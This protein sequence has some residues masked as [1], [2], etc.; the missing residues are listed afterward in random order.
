MTMKKP[1]PYT[2]KRIL[3]WFVGFFLIV[4]L[5]NG[6]M[7]YFALTTWPGLETEKPYIKGLNYNQEITNAK[8]QRI[9]NWQIMITE[10]PTKTKDGYFEI[11]ITKPDES[12]APTQVNATFFRAVQEGFDQKITLAPLGN[13]RYGAPVNLPL[14]GQWDIFIVVKSQNNSIYKHKDWVLIR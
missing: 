10:K 9:S 12:L 14:Q 6:I 7:T 2:G 3:A 1:K 4:F 13:D 11:S 5:A 8:N